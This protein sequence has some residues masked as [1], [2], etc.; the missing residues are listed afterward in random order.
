MATFTLEISD[1]RVEEVLS[2][3]IITANDWKVLIKT[4]NSPGTESVK[5][6]PG[7]GGLIGQV[8]RVTKFLFVHKNKPVP[9]NHATYCQWYV[10][11]E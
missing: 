8:C 4:E 10:A 9:T 6:I 7:I 3:E 11:V 5:N 1:M 2:E